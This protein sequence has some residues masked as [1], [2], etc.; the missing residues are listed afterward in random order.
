[1]VGKDE[2]TWKCEKLLRVN[3]VGALLIYYMNQEFSY[4]YSI[5]HTLPII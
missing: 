5:T 2:H 3:K 1:M 4:K